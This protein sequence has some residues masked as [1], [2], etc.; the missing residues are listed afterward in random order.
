M[1]RL[2]R[3]EANRQ[4]REGIAKSAENTVPACADD[5]ELFSQFLAYSASSAGVVSLDYM[6]R[7]LV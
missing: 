1:R 2:R 7:S 4:K 5:A 3:T 6:I